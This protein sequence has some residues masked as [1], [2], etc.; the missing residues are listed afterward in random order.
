M[1]KSK[2]MKTVWH[3]FSMSVMFMG[4]LLVSTGTHCSHNVT[5]RPAPCSLSPD[6]CNLVAEWKKDVGGCL[7]I[8]T[9]GM[10]QN[11]TNS[12]PTNLLNLN[13]LQLYLGPA[14]NRRSNFDYK[15]LEYYYNSPCSGN[16][17]VDSSDKRWVEFAFDAQT[18]QFKSVS[19]YAQ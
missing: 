13:S 15:T 17:P 9:F 14:D 6:L 1:V 11:I 8:R 7:H 5:S 2:I 4:V 3:S 12:M 19:K 16:A 10:A 18:R